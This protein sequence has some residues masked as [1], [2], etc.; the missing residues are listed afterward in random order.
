MHPLETLD[1][2]L[3]Q[4]IDTHIAYE[5][6]GELLGGV[7]FNERLRIVRGLGH[8]VGGNIDVDLEKCC[9][10]HPE[11]VECQVAAAHRE[12]TQETDVAAGRLLCLSHRGRQ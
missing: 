5:L 11:T 9:L 4:V 8:V 10:A 12:V 6:Q 3:P 7:R 1:E 2:C